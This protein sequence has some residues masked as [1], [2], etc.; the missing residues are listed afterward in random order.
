MNSSIAQTSG[1]QSSTGRSLS[2]LTKH[3]RYVRTCLT[4]LDIAS[5]ANFEVCDA[6]NPKY[7]WDCPIVDVLKKKTP[8]NQKNLTKKPHMQCQIFC[9]CSC[10]QDALLS[11][12]P[13]SR[14][15]PHSQ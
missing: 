14:P 15:R 1:F 9:A 5:A 7:V 13:S 8:Q 10:M 4:I 11:R 6:I 3:A 2:G 12:D